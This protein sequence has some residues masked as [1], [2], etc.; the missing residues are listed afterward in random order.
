MQTNS[1]RRFDWLFPGILK[2]I[3]IDQKAGYP[4]CTGRAEAEAREVLHK[5]VQETARSF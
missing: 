2:K 4:G 1:E 5:S 3:Q